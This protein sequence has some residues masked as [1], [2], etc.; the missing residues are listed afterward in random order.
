VP[1]LRTEP[2]GVADE[3]QTIHV[4]LRALHE[5]L[6]SQA[7]RAPYA[8]VTQRLQAIGAIEEKNAVAVARRLAALGRHADENGAGAVAEGRNAWERLVK[9]LDAYR[10]LIRRLKLLSVRWDD[11]HPEDASL[12]AALRDSAQASRAIVGDLIARSDPHAL[13]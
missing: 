4:Q 1:W 3:L 13:D 8:F 7:D 12:V 6:E 11:E 9:L 10:E 5:Q 2:A